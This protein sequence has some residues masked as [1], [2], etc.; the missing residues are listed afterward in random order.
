MG[1]GEDEEDCGPLCTLF[2]L[3]NGLRGGMHNI[4]QRVYGNGTKSIFDKEYD[5]HNS[6][7]E[8]KVLEDGTKVAINRTVI[9]DKDGFGNSIY[10]KTFISEN[11]QTDSGEEVTIEV[12]DKKPADTA[13]EIASEEFEVPDPSENEIDAENEIEKEA[14]IDYG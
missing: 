10:I 1:E 11:I 4:H 6:T 8:E 14:G 3:V 12:T 2:G 9:A 13:E 5:L 7:Y